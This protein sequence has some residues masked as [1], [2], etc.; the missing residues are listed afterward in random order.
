MYFVLRTLKQNNPHHSFAPYSVLSFGL[1][2]EEKTSKKESR[3]LHIPLNI[4]NFIK[5]FTLKQGK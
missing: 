4:F 2:V 5:V 1:V 3:H